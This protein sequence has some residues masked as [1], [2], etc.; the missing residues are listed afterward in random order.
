MTRTIFPS[1]R[2]APA[3][4]SDLSAPPV[5]AERTLLAAAPSAARDAQAGELYPTILVAAAIY[6]VAL[7]A[8]ALLEVR[9]D[10]LDGVPLCIGP[11]AFLCLYSRMA[12]PRAVRTTR[13]IEAAFIVVVLGLS[14]ACLSYLGAMADLPLRDREMIWIDRHLGFDW[15][16]M[17]QA[18]DRRP[19]VLA[20]LDGAYATFTSQLIGTVLLLILAE[21]TREL[22]RFFLTF[23]CASAMAEIA[24]VLV[25]TLG[26]MSAA[27]GQAVFAHLPTLG[28]TTAEIVLKLRDGALRAID[29]QAIDGIIS[30]P[31]LHAAVSVIVPFSLRWNRPLFWPIAVLDAVMLVSAVP[32]GNHYLVDVIGGVCVAVLAILCSS[33]IQTSLDR[34]MQSFGGTRPAHQPQP[35]APLRAPS[36]SAQQAPRRHYEILTPP[37]HYRHRP[38]SWEDPP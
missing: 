33:P 26:P 22:D 20:V 18:L 34:L 36:S 14:L 3:C 30:F 29:L 7:G 25:P 16:T 28:R 24:S 4:R 17:M 12:F 31:S 35:E 15:L 38:G 21:R 8:S 27:G 13:L 19:L 10:V 23:V 5:P 37:A 9:A 6:V 1:G 2:V 11:G 32:S